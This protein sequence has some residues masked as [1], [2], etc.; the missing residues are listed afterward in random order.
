MPAARSAETTRIRAR[1]GAHAHGAQE[2]GDELNRVEH[3][4]GHPLFRFDAQL[5]Q[6]SGHPLDLGQ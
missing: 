1:H 4:H 3:G 6:R 2:D 5:P